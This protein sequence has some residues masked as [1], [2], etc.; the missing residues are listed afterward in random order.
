MKGKTHCEVRNRIGL[1][2]GMPL[3][4]GREGVIRCL[5]V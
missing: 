4:T 5:Q 2:A 3:E 1:G